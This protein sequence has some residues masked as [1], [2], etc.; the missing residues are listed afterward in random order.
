MGALGW[1]LVA[2][3]GFASARIGVTLTLASAVTTQLVFG[4]WFDARVGNVDF[5]PQVAVGAGLLL[6]GLLLI[7]GRG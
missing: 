5:G 6:I 3:L 7:A 4:L 1:L 2:A